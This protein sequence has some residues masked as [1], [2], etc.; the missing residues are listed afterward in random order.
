MRGEPTGGS[1][2]SDARAALSATKDRRVLL[3]ALSTIASLAYDLNRTGN[4]RSDYEAFCST[5]LAQVRVFDPGNS[6]TCDTSALQA[7][8]SQVS[9]AVQQARLIRQ[10]RPL[11]PPGAKALGI[12][13]TVW[14]SATIGKDG[15]VRGLG[16]LS[17]PLALYPTSRT[18]VLQWEYAPTLSNG[19]PIEVSTRLCVNYV[20]RR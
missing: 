14:F 2:G 7:G 13:G 18:T 8:T 20:L 19:R 4:L 5:L 17:G 15:K 9:A 6:N 11:Y 12:A 16:F 1:F 3:S 10:E